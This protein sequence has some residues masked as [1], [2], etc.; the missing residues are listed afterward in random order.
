MSPLALSTLIAAAALALCVIYGVARA[1]RNDANPLR[2]PKLPQLSAASAIYKTAR[3]ERLPLLHAAESSG[4]KPTEW[5]ASSI[6]G[7]VLTC[8]RS[9]LGFE[10]S[11]WGDCDPQ[12]LYIARGMFAPIC[13]GRA[14]CS[15]G[16]L[17]AHG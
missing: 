2:G 16:A 3:R 17:P 11:N 9:S 4:E 5:F 1:R 8:K 13:A 10:V 7:V 14:R 6:D 15:N 12:S